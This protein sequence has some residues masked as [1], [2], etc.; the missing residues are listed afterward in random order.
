MSPRRSLS[1]GEPAVAAECTTARQLASGHVYQKSTKVSCTNRAVHC[2]EFFSTFML[3][4]S[5]YA[6][7]IGKPS[8]GNVG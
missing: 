3:V 8:F 5:V 7:A 4:A 1:A 6:V 2:R